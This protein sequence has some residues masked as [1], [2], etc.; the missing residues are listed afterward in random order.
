MLAAPL[1]L[2]AA[3]TQSGLYRC[4]HRDHERGE[5]LAAAVSGRG[6]LDDAEQ[7]REHAD[8]DGDLPGRG[9]PHRERVRT[10]PDRISS[11][12]RARMASS[13]CFIR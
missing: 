6:S 13:T 12:R 2:P 10:G 5:H 11:S 8:G 1:A 7:Q 9:G 4:D 3:S